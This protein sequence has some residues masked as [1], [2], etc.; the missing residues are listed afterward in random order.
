M[1]VSETV[2]EYDKNSDLYE[3]VLGDTELKQWIVLYAG[4]AYTN[5]I[6]RIKKETG[7]DIEWNGDVTVEI[8]VETFARDF[9]EFLMAISEENFIRGYRQAFIDIETGIAMASEE[10]DSDGKS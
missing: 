2:S 3:K 8:I 7:K 9:P 1:I 6:K 10:V 5:E 4:R